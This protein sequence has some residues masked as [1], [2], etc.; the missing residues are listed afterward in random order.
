M[1]GST[2]FFAGRG[3]GEGEHE[4]VGGCVV[5]EQDLETDSLG[6]S[7]TRQ[8]IWADLQSALKTSSG[9]KHTD[10]AVHGLSLS[11]HGT[12]QL[13]VPRNGRR[14]ERDGPRDFFEVHIIAQDTGG[15]RHSRPKLTDTGEI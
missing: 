15:T 10:G 14:R 3:V 12:G 1:D 9:S 8:Q 13:G 4:T 5:A 7:F 11:V 2:V 6:S